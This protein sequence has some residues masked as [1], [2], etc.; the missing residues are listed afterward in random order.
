MG[1][2]SAIKLTERFEVENL[3]L[4]VPAVYTSRVYDVPFGP[5]FSTIIREVESWANS[6]AFKTMAKFAGSITIIA[7]EFDHVIPIKLI[8]QLNASARSAKK[9]TL[10]TVPNSRHLSLFPLENDFLAAM[11]LLLEALKDRRGI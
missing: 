1:A 10:H 3:I 2:Y 9:R 7:A 5:R 8:D 6:D 11:D 4:L